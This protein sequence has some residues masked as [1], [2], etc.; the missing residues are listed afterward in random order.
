MI[1]EQKSA[2][3]GARAL[4]V[5]LYLY[6]QKQNLKNKIDNRYG[7]DAEKGTDGVIDAGFQRV[8]IV[9]HCHLRDIRGWRCGEHHDDRLQDGQICRKAGG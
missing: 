3:A 8:L 1:S 2:R 4:F 5:A 7:Q 9:E 6:L